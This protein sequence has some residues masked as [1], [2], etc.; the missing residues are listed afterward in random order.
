MS[1]EKKK[2]S[3]KIYYATH[4]EQKNLEKNKA[5][6]KINYKKVYEYKQ[7]RFSEGCQLCSFSDPDCLCLHHPKGVYKTTDPS[8]VSYLSSRAKNEL[9]RCIVLCMNCHTKL[10]AVERRTDE[11]VV[12]IDQICP[13]ETI[14]SVIPSFS[15]QCE[16]FN[17]ENS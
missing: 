1:T 10:H 11:Q 17:F 3:D 16:L 6:Q 8:K 7:Q 12:Q 14:D 9:D 2:E 15:I 13:I 4:K 5:R